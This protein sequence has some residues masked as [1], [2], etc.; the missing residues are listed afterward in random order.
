VSRFRVLRGGSCNRDS[1]N[2]RSTFRNWNEPEFRRRFVGFR[3]VVIRRK[4]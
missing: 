2:L 3:I 4:P 1:W